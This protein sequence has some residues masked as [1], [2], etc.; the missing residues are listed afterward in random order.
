MVLAPRSS[1]T[2]KFKTEQIAHVGL[3]PEDN[4]WSRQGI[5]WAN[6]SASSIVREELQPEDPKETSLNEH[7]G[8]H[9]AIFSEAILAFAASRF[10][11]WVLSN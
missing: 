5:L 2:L 8:E 3:M 11:F 4:W 6:F 1:T 9:L 7:F 10:V